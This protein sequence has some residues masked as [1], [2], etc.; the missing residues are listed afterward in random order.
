MR[1]HQQYAFIN[2]KII[3]VNPRFS[4]EEAL[5]IEGETIVAVGSTSKI[6]GLQE[7]DAIVRDLHG[8]S[9]IPGM[10]DCHAHLD[11][12]GLKAVFPA[13]GK[14]RS[15]PDI[16]NRIAQL[17][18]QAKPG[19]WIVTMPIGDPP[20]YF[21]VP[22]IL[23]EKRFPNRYELDE[24]SPNNPV[25]IKPI[26]G[27]WRHTF[28]LVSIA[29]S[30]ALELAK[31]D[32]HFQSGSELIEIDRDDNGKPTGIFY[33]NTMMPILELTAFNMIPR[34]TNEDRTRGLKEACLA[35]HRYATTG[36]FEEH[37]VVT[38]LLSAYKKAEA[39]GS[40]TM[41]T[42]LVISPLW[43]PALKKNFQDFLR[44]WLGWLSEPTI[45]SKNLKCTGL[46]VDIHPQKENALRA[47]ALPY[48]GWAGFNYDTAVSPE[49]A[50][51]L[52][53]A[54]VLNDIRVVAI[55]PNM[56]D[57]FY[58]VHQRHSLKG[59]RW[60]L[61][62]IASLSDSQMDKIAEMELIISTHTNRYIYKEGH[63]LKAKLG[64]E[65]ES[66]IAPIQSLL[67]K[68]VVVAMASD[69]VPVSMFYPIWQAI[70]R[71]NLWTG[72]TIGADQ[73]ISREDALRC[74]TINGA[75]FTFDEDRTGSL[76]AGKYADFA[77][78]NND[79][80]TCLIDDIKD[81]EAI[82]T[83]VGGNKVYENRP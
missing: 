17:C 54:C 65:R 45:G 72:E 35:Y 74:A 30:K 50:Y 66:E 58:R 25:Y 48:T 44:N 64:I 77:I 55:W 70:K 34:F 29:N 51:E 16:Q 69:N 47:K 46:F 19:E 52:C 56:I 39:N 27:F 7:S 67:D 62:H 3:T 63:L 33:E 60:V 71:Q 40:L 4:I 13:L 20:T 42:A 80:L 26:W 68:G 28:P 12:E 6:M 10:V 73:A 61:G 81:I 57:I 22:D 41:R 83:Y 24:V 36:I 32:E 75:K 78:L 9:V 5:L 31:I 79:P 38:E 59:R 15:I 8:K 2:G 82:E 53:V 18:S 76:E 11:R 1:K 14:V 49:E 37:G 23:T 21:N 43:K